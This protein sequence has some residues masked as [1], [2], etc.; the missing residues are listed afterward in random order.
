MSVPNSIHSLDSSL[1]P[2]ARHTDTPFLARLRFRNFL[3]FGPES[4]WIKLRN[5]N[6][7]IGPNGSGKSNFLSAVEILRRGAERDIQTALGAGGRASDFVWKGA[8]RL[9]AFDIEAEFSNPFDQYPL[10]YCVQLS[11]VSDLFGIADERLVRQPEVGLPDVG[12][13]SPIF[14]R[15][16]GNPPKPFL[17]IRGLDD[18]NSRS[19][20]QNPDLPANALIF[21][22]RE[23]RLYPEIT[24]LGERLEQTR[25]YRFPDL[26]TRVPLRI[27]QSPSVQGEFLNEDASNLNKLL[28]NLRELPGA[29]ERIESGLKEFM[30]G[31]SRIH[32]HAGYNS[33][34]L[35]LSE[36]GLSTPIPS[37]RLSDGTLRYLILLF[38]LTHPSPPPLMCI[39][40]P[41]IGL[42]PDMIYGLGKLLLDA[43]ARTQLIVTTHS[44]VLI[45]ALSGSPEAV[46]ICEKN[47][48]V[49]DLKRL[50]L[51]ELDDW[52]ADYSLG[53]LWRQGHLG[54]NR[55]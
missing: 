46:L 33:F 22:R 45:N 16:F 35:R 51:T 52:L 15:A 42:H 28:N 44:D 8:E 37:A 24:Y 2:D 53:D 19:A 3:S 12:K 39:E 1:P 25:I 47:K 43:S 40:E 17:E 27:P 18:P 13:G 55:W 23:Q 29:F 26:D 32:I 6:V 5:L 20:V 4:D 30:P 48:G 54:G 50:Q 38:V 10:G 41:E 7:L 36:E 14:A 9:S 11:A 21:S 31:I 49:T 34:E